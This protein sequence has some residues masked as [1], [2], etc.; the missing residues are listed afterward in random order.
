MEYPYINIHTHDTSEEA[1]TVTSAGIHPWDAEEH[2]LSDRDEKR[3]IEEA[4]SESQIV[5]EIGLDFAAEVDRDAQQQLFKGQLK[6]AKKH[7][8]PVLLHS[9]RA[10]DATMLVLSTFNL[11][12]VIFHGFIGSVQQMNTAVD[13]GYYIS[14]GDRTFASPKTLKALRECPI[15][16]LFI[17]TDTAKVSIEEL[18][19]KISKQRMESVEELR[20]AIYDNYKRIFPTT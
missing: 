14:F 3:E 12:G 15:E 7:N 19:A 17:E 18:Y 20:K 16:R 10:F 6:L 8:K 2:D 1:L 9:V 4:I 11:R 13:R 5:G